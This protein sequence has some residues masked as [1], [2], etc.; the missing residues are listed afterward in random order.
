MNY[1]YT[2]IKA[3]ISGTITSRLVNLGDQITNNQQMFDIVDFDSMVARVYLPE[4]HL[5]MLK[6]GQKA[7][8]QSQAWVIT[9]LKE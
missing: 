5:P 3:P 9:L 2:K 7:N 1:N 8:I 6:V 4:K